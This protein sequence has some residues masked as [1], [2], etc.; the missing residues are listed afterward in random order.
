[1]QEKGKKKPRV[2]NVYELIFRLVTFVAGSPNGGYTKL[3]LLCLILAMLY[4]LQKN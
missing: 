1:M 3:V 4:I 2:R